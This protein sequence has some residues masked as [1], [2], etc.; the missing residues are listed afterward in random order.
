MLLAVV[1]AQAAT[2]YSLTDLG[3]LSDGLSE[4]F[5]INATG[6][7]VGDSPNGTPHTGFVYNGSLTPLGT[8]GGDESLA[9]SIN[10]AGLIVG[11]ST[12]AAGNRYAFTATTPTTLTPLNPWGG[13]FSTA[14]RV[15]GSYIVG[16]AENATA[17]LRA[18]R[19]NG[20]ATL[21]LGTLGGDTSI[22][23]GVNAAGQV[24][25]QADTAAGIGHAFYHA[26]GATDTP[27]DLGALSTDAT[28]A[29]AAY[30]INNAR[31]IV[32]W[33]H[34]GSETTF[35]LERH[36]FF[37]ADGGLM[38]D[39]GALG[40]GDSVAYD[41]NNQGQIVGAAGAAAVGFLYDTNTL[42][43]VDLN[44]LVGNPQGWSITSARAINDSGWIVASASNGVE[45]HAVLL[46]PVPEPSTWA[47]LTL[48][49]GCGLFA[50]LRQVSAR[51][52]ASAAHV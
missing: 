22:G 30:A 39:L 3:A 51:R 9:R 34:T 2:T 1:P 31:S 37:K 7:V 10:S 43:M 47:L 50:I 45:T 4:G 26:G 21:D 40:F 17:Q 12:D 23:Y 24:V 29:S 32:G 52:S 49:V 8:L 35:N 41:I 5:G 38:Q 11:E 16:Q 27:V 20:A 6:V 33:T 44:T 15:N 14:W 36:A 28:A 46:T 42:Q 19:S 13:T 18:F 25:G 48:G